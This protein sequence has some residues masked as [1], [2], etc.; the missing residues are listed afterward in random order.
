GLPA[1]GPQPGG[2]ASRGAQGASLRA[3]QRAGVV[4]SEGGGARAVPERG[5]GGPR[6]PRRGR[7]HPAAFQRQRPPAGAAQAGGDSRRA[8]GA[9][10]ARGRSEEHTSELQSLT[11]LVCRLLL[12]KKN[13][14]KRTPH[15]QTT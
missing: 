4:G 1:E 3:G 11:N 9:G 12:E 10:V 14:Q 8:P 7:A 2:A 6:L 5:G 13:T 15:Q